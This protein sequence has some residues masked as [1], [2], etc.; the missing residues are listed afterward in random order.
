MRARSESC[1]CPA[2]DSRTT[3]R[4]ADGGT[5]SSSLSLIRF[6]PTTAS[7][8]SSGVAA[9]ARAIQ[10]SDKQHALPARAPSRCPA[11]WRTT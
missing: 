8:N 11:N 2:A 4:D 10:Q 1:T 5:S 6:A 3:A 9:A 7:A